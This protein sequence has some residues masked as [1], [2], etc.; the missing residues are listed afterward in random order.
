MNMVVCSLTQQLWLLPR[1]PRDSSHFL[2]ILAWKN[3]GPSKSKINVSYQPG[4]KLAGNRILLSNL[5]W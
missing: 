4:P 1:G 5:N 2:F 3:S